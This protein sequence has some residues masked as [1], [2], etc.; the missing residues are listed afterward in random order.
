MAHDVL[1]YRPMLR[2]VLVLILVAGTA[3]SA[4]AGGYLGLGVGNGAS[5]G[6]DI[7]LETDGRTIRLMGGYRFGRF[8]VEGLGTRY[9][10]VRSDGHEYTGTTVGV[11]GRFNFS[12]GYNFE[13]YGR[14][15]LQYTQLD[16]KVYEETYNG[17]GI[18]IGPGVEYRIPLGTMALAFYV[19]ANVQYASVKNEFSDEGL[20]LTQAWWTLGAMF[21]F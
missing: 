17:F 18:L 7:D 1:Y 11:A 14:A 13:L 6:G 2:S 19:D 20:D 4:S 15:G 10:L 9:D 5:S 12:L 21:Y 8:A 16:P 3:G